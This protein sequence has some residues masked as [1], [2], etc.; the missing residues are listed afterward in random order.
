MDFN[1]LQRQSLYNYTPGNITVRYMYPT[2]NHFVF[3]DSDSVLYR[4]STNEVEQ[5]ITFQ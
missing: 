3:A 2:I 4:L 1:H 5:F